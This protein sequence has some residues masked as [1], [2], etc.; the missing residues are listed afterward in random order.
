VPR[1]ATYDKDTREALLVAAGR[2]L[3]GEGA[4]Q[5][6][7]RR[8]A[9]EVGATTSAIYA[10]F[11]SKQEVVRAMYREGFEHLTRLEAEVDQADPVARIRALAYAYRRA[12]LDR[13]HLYQVMF[14]C[15]VPDFIPDDEDMAIGQGSL[16]ILRDAVA[17]AVAAQAIRGDVDT[18]TVAMWAL[19]HGLA[20]LELNGSLAHQTDPDAV[21]ETSLDASL[22]GLRA[23]AA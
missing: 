6:T 21:W 20:S 5:L 17:D 2:I 15:P 4:A 8:L 3:A 16:F 13:P 1:P 7:M 9:G 23:S 22:S 19:V 12:A 18:I 10:L 14:A 11:G